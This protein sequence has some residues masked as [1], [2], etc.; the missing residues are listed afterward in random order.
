MTTAPEK[1]PENKSWYP[2][3]I[4]NPPDIPSTSQIFTFK[5]KTIEGKT[6][7]IG[8]NSWFVAKLAGWY[9]GWKHMYFLNAVAEK[10]AFKV[11][12]EGKFIRMIDEASCNW[13]AIHIQDGKIEENRTTLMYLFIEC[14]GT[15]FS[16]EKDGTIR[17]SSSLN[18]EGLVLGLSPNSK[19]LCLVN[20]NSQNAIIFD[21]PLQQNEPYVPKQITS[22]LSMFKK[23]AIENCQEWRG[24]NV[25]PEDIDISHHSGLGGALT[26]WLELNDL[27]FGEFVDEKL[28]LKFGILK[29]IVAQYERMSD[30]AKLMAE[31][32][33]TPK[34]LYSNEMYMLSGW[35][36]DKLP[37]DVDTYCLVGKALAKMHKIPTDWFKRYKKQTL[38]SAI[39]SQINLS[40]YPNIGNSYFWILNTRDYFRAVFTNPEVLEFYLEHEFQPLHPLLKRVVSAH[41]DLHTDNMLLN[42]SDTQD[43]HVNFI[44]MEHVCATSAVHDFAYFFH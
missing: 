27:K 35:G 41:G 25:L 13:N 21:T 22:N 17:S 8:D 24:N 38:G 29:D 18:L 32:G 7:F 4:P 23:L 11:A 43:N 39:F 14:E 16:L 33:V 44:D 31:A 28:V 15:K 36:G 3:H 6:I 40:D 34:L 37:N 30:M 5:G 2:I 9:L 26:Y 19:D 12:F 42:H 1:L 10:N 20:P